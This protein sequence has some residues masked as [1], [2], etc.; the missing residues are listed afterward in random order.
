MTKCTRIWSFILEDRTKIDVIQN[1]QLK[2]LNFV[3]VVA[4]VNM[5]S[6]YKLTYIKKCFKT[7]KIW[8]K[9]PILS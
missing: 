8:K 7:Q 4:N 3:H 6:P 2:K 5:T 9:L 1:D